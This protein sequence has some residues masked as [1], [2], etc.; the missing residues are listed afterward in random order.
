MAVRNFAWADLASLAE[1]IY[2]VRTAQG[3]ERLLTPALLKEELA[4]PGLHPEENC[5]L[6]EDG[7]GLW[8]YS[9]VHPEPRMGRVILEIGIHPSHSETGVEQEIVGS[10]LARAKE[11]EA[12]GAPHMSTF[13]GVLEQYHGGRRSLAGKGLLAD[14]LARG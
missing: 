9:V 14:A 7:Q 2:V 5:F 11:L 1:F 10:A 3:D 6:F 8:A 12:R 13:L 4:L